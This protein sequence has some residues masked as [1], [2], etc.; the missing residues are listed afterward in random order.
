MA[1]RC[2]ETLRPALLVLLQHHA[3][4]NKNSE[5]KGVL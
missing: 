5:L 4:L 3:I 1:E 2:D